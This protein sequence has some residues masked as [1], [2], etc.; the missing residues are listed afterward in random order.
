MWCNPWGL[1]WEEVRASDILRLDAD[2]EIVDGQWDVTPAVFLH[3]ELH[4]ARADARVIVHNH[5]YYATLL[6]DDRRAAASGAPEL[7][8]LRR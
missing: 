3:T 1:W 2:G 8:H 7:V 6:V 5:P 4:R